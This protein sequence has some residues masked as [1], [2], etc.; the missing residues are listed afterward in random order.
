M[1][2]TKPSLISRQNCTLS[3]PQDST[4]ITLLTLGTAYSCIIKIT[5]TKWAPE[6]MSHTARSAISNFKTNLSG[7]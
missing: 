4:L 3:G 5:S 1:P 2:I 7:S 6:E